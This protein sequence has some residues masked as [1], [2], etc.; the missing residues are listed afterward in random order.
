MVADGALPSCGHYA[1]QRCSCGGLASR[2][3]SRSTTGISSCCRGALRL[4][5]TQAA[6][7][8]AVLSGT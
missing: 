3:C 4:I 7:P 1:L 8:L 6:R 2:G 5:R